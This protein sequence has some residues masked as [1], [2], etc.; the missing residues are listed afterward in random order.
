MLIENQSTR[1]RNSITARIRT[2]NRFS[3]STRVIGLWLGLVTMSKLE[4][5]T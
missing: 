2:R 5:I 1:T 4:T 3:T